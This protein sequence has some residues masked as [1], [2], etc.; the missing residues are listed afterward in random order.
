M[1]FEIPHM[2]GNNLKSLIWREMTLVM[3]LYRQYTR[4]LQETTS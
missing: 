2:T 1:E 3:I 4:F